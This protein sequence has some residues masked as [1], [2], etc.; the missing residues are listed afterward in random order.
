MAN[1]IRVGIIGFDTSHVPAFAKVLNDPQDQWHVPGAVVTHGYASFSPDLQASYSRVEGFKRD[2][3]GKYGVK[4]VDSVDALVAEVDAVLLESVDGRRHLAEARPVI[5][6]HKPLFIDKPLAANYDE[7]AEIMRLAAEAGSA[8]FSS[9]SLRFDANIL[10]IKSDLEVGKVIACDA[11]SPAHLDPTNPGLFWYGVHG[12]EILYTFMGAG[13]QKLACHSNDAYDLVFG[14]WSDGR[15]GTLRGI[16][17]G[18]GNYGA[19]V[20]GE[21]KVRQATYSTTI[22]IYSQLLKEIVAFFKT[23][24]APVPAAETLEIMAFMQAA[25]VSAAEHREVKLAEVR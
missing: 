4:L 10:A 8:V 12:V 16:R 20:F 22:P 17:A 7:A 11:F 21:K 13:C 14:E 23:G 24:V 2:V 19:T 5:A 1:D 18:A 15:I 6:A 9:S 25:L 3:T